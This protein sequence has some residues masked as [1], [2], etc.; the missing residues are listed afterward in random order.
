MVWDKR[1]LFYF[2][3]LSEVD[4]WQTFCIIISLWT[5]WA[6]KYEGTVLRCRSASILS[7]IY[8]EMSKDFLIWP[9][10]IVHF[11]LNESLLGSWTVTHNLCLIKLMIL[12]FFSK[13]IVNSTRRLIYLVTL[14]IF[15][16][17][18]FIIQILAMKCMTN[19]SGPLRYLN[20]GNIF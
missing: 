6:F 15:W 19:Y 14:H 16:H 5:S 12:E 11:F 9:F 20:S 4:V 13:T 2:L 1:K 3:N 18:N 17:I 8:Q 10:S 7:R